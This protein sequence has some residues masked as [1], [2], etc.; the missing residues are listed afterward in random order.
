MAGEHTFFTHDGHLSEAALTAIADG[1]DDYFSHD[2]VNHLDHCEHCTARLGDAAFLSVQ[3]GDALA[4]LGKLPATEA[5]T[6]TPPPRWLV[7][8]VATLAV[9]SLGV[10][11]VGWLRADPVESASMLSDA[12]SDYASLPAVSQV[13][14]A[15]QF[16]AP[17]VFLCAALAAGMFASRSLARSAS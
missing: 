4:S 6:A 3:V 11:S 1:Q 13:I 2:V 8:M 14:H 5:S 15:L 12:A 9:G 10:R 17:L 16:A 7:A